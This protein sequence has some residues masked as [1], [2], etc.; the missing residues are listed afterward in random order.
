MSTP[1]A[2]IS[3]PCE[4]SSN[5][6]VSKTP[7]LTPKSNRL[8]MQENMSPI[9]YSPRQLPASPTRSSPGSPRKKSRQQYGDRFI[10]SRNGINL[11]AAF[12]IEK[13]DVNNTSKLFNT[14]LSGSRSNK[15]TTKSQQAIE[16]DKTFSL[17]LKSEMFGDYVPSSIPLSDNA[18]ERGGL[19]RSL[20]SR[21]AS[22]G[23]GAADILPETASNTPT[24]SSRLSAPV[25]PN[26]NLFRYQSPSRSKV[27]TSSL[28]T[29]P[30]SSTHT[31]PFEGSLDL[32]FPELTR[33]NLPESM[34]TSTRPSNYSEK[35][36][37][38]FTSQRHNTRSDIFTN[39]Q[40]FRENSNI[41]VQ[42]SQQHTHSRSALSM[43]TEF[44]DPTNSI[45][46]LS[47]MRPESQRLLLQKKKEPRK[48]PTIPYRV[49]DAPGLVDDYYLNLLDWSSKNVIGV[50]L[51]SSVYLW[52]AQNNGVK[53]LLD[54][55][56]DDFVTSVSW[57]KRGTHLAVGTNKGLVQIWDA[58]RC[59]RVRTMTGHDMRTGALAW[60]EHILSSGSRDRTILHHDV[61]IP[62]HYVTRL[63]GHRQEVCGLQWNIQENK[64]ASGGN[65]N[66]LLIWD[67]LNETPL[68]RF[69]DHTAAVKAL[70]WSPHQRGLLASGCGTADRRIRFWNTATGVLL[71]EL[72]TE[73]QVCSLAWSRTSNE[74]VSTHGYSKNQ[75]SVW[76][77]PSL[78][79]VA[80]LTGHGCRVLYLALS[81]DGMSAVTGAGLGD[82]TLRFWK[83]FDHSQNKKKM[84]T[85]LQESFMQM[86]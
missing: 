51:Q 45:Y 73:S 70:A 46:S 35:T 78:T 75:V 80:S 20:G 38:D 77:Y 82:E 67:G 5:I 19:T 28:A 47:P 62:D 12:S 11:Q 3:D 39:N 65:D 40:E 66:K 23:T 4:L 58:E 48:V 7:P 50:A 52:N 84:P 57:I 69:T 30:P 83:L 68:H 13:D 63:S 15:Y 33:R 9:H 72:V 27:Y 14:N 55:G 41:N 76:R 59:K 43:M 32:M 36:N 61:R 44:L 85:F 26:S 10:P 64:L 17:L 54:L 21:T 53:K 2:A 31:K 56:A 18:F 74:L 79:Q 22:S 34:E 24:R 25:T 29:P 1:S 8:K 16:A 42:E 49:L 60:N 37:Q 71:D 81:P 86:R 6:M